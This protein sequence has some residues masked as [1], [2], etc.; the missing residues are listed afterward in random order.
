V[1][2][3]W[4]QTLG[5]ALPSCKEVQI[6]G[7]GARL[8]RYAQTRTINMCAVGHLTR[9][10]SWISHLANFNLVMR[11]QLAALEHALCTYFASVEVV[12]IIARRWLAR[13]NWMQL[14][15]HGAH[16]QPQRSS[17]SPT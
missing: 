6:S 14:C 5:F 15:K 4:P 9:Y 1:A 2:R 8:Q 7:G 12:S 16:A 11:N 17:T 13:M 10:E 3:L